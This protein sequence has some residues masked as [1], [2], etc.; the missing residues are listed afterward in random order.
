MN[1][2]TET[3]SMVSQPD[4]WVA[5]L[6]T[7]AM[8]S[9]VLAILILVL[10]L[11]KRVLYLKAG[12]SQGRLIQMLSSYHLAPKERIAL[13]DVAGEKMVIGISA[14]NITCLAKIE[15]PEALAQIENSKGAMIKGDG[16]FMDTLLS[17]LR[18]K[19]TAGE[20]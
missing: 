19:R 9:V 5:V 18:R 12:S 14:G 8:L 1:G 10:F 11:M 13:I 16:S 20:R 4:L 15:K 6:K 17:S 3:S 7:M 2:L